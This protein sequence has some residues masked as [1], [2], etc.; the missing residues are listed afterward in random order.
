MLIL[1]FTLSLFRNRFL[2]FYLAIHPLSLALSFCLSACR[3]ILTLPLFT[4]HRDICFLFGAMSAATDPVAVVA[5]L[6]ELGAPE[7]LGVLV[8]GESLINDGSAFVAFLV[9]IDVINGDLL[10]CCCPHPLPV[11]LARPRF[12]LAVHK[13]Q[14]SIHTR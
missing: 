4:F 13:L 10:I 3:H 1:C 5:L 14:C 7:S 8:E 12:P 6:G 11:Q 9:M 2:A